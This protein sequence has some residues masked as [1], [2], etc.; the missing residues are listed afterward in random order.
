M[1]A[2]CSS[3]VDEGTW[4]CYSTT[5]PLTNMT[6]A[7]T[8]TVCPLCSARVGEEELAY[9]SGTSTPEG[10]GMATLA[11]MEFQGASCSLTAAWACWDSWHQEGATLAG[12][13]VE[14]TVDMAACQGE[15]RGSSLCSLCSLCSWCM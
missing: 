5:L 15:V 11:T 6:A 2:T 3:M 1:Q 7:T 10:S 12:V 4:P 9:T 14:A 8:V 13:R